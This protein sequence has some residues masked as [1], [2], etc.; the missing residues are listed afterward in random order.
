MTSPVFR[1]ASVLAV[2]AVLALLGLR[3]SAQNG[4]APALVITAYDG[5]LPADYVVPR[6]PWGDPDLQGVWSSDDTGGIPLERPEALGTRLYQTD[7]EYAERVQRVKEGAE[8]ALNTVGAFRTDFAT[9]AF[10]QTS[11]IVDPPDGRMPAFTAQAETRRA[12]RDRGTFGEG[13][14]NW[15]DDFTLFERCITRGIVG[16]ILRVPYGNGNTIVQGPGLVAISYEMMHD[17]RILHTDGRPP[18][19]DDVRLY[20]GDSRARWEGDELVVVTTNLTDRTSIGSDGSGL[21][22]SDQMLI[23]ERFK[24]VAHDVLQYQVTVEDPITYERPFT[25]SFPLTPLS[26]GRVLPYDCHEGNM[27]VLQTL[28]GER[29]ED[30]ALAEDLAR[31]IVRERRP[32]QGN[33]EGPVAALPEVVARVNGEPIESWELENAVRAA[34][35]NT[36]SP[37]PIDR[38]DEVRRE[39][40]TQ[41]VELRLLGQEARNRKIAPTD[42][43]VAAE[44]NQI[45]RG[46]P[47]DEA[48]AR[49]LA[50]DGT[51]LDRVEQDVA[52][53]LAVGKLL[54]RQVRP[55]NSIQETDLRTFYENNLDRF[56]VSESVRA[57]HILI[58]VAPPATDGEW[59]QARAKADELLNK[60]RA[61]SDFAD[62]AR[63]ESQDAGTAPLGG[64]LGFFARGQ[65]VPALETIV[66][67]LEPGEVGPVVETQFGLHIIQQVEQRPSRIAPFD[68][69]RQQIEQLLQAGQAEARTAD[70]LVQSLRATARIEIFLEAS[71]QN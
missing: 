23:T 49:A 17:T 39:L 43:E 45:R 21:R 7:E 53:R 31:G 36:G 15:T 57:R 12:T 52:R 56:K 63:A 28:G 64:D 54:A 2:A 46:F 50:E 29:A 25:L 26:G 71:P 9:R 67:D 61:G 6:T 14:F 34:E 8:R 40:L 51:S 19:G 13:P 42:A 68:E 38:R 62:L 22:H 18:V 16:S 55:T 48:F 32:V 10:R 20:L 65:M 60:V 35:L 11:L 70:A 5:R 66:F 37:V 41:L 69:V 47:S 27:G 24:R 59:D 30:I 44:L 4:D 58:A 33:V 3:V 1:L